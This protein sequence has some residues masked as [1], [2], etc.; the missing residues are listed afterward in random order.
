MPGHDR[1]CVYCRQDLEWSGGASRVS[2]CTVGYLG[3][4]VPTLETARCQAAEA[5][6]EQLATALTGSKRQADR[7]KAPIKKEDMGAAG[8]SNAACSVL[9]SQHY[10]VDCL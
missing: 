7:Q 1:P 4:A 5:H 6:S 3:D 10:L 8:A 2:P 9:V